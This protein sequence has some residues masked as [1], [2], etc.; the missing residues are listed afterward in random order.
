MFA[1]ERQHQIVARLR[2]EGAVRTTVLADEFAVAE[3]TIRR[4]LVQLSRR[5]LL[6]RTHGGGVDPSAGRFELA[7]EER[8]RRQVREKRRIARAA[9]RW[10]ESGDTVLLDASSTALELA[11]VL[12]PDIRVVTY[13][14][15]VVER[16]GARAD[17]ELLQLGGVFDPRGRR[18]GGLLAESALRSLPIDRFLFSGGGFD[19]RQGVA[20]PNPGQAS[21]KRLAIE[22]AR[23]SCALLDHSKL[24]AA[25]EW[26]FAGP[27]E[28][29]HLI[30]DA[31]GAEFFASHPLSYELQSTN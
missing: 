11:L 3:E 10:I 27:E 13:S 5:G 2:R 7:H 9:A 22:L 28:F 18:F 29:Q 26:F 8:E 23:W 21:I 16:L 12:P 30:T 20:E 4:D 31:R 24:G 14:L 15:A 1:S 17:L 25:A 19:L 6:K